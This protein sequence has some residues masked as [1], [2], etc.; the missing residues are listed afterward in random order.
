MGVV[1]NAS[2]GIGKAL[3]LRVFITITHHKL[4]VLLS[5]SLFGAWLSLVERT[6][7]DR[8]V[9]GSNPLAPTI[10]FCSIGLF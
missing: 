9:G 5:L 8:E 1:I 7:R 6:V 2:S 4:V 10:H 3:A